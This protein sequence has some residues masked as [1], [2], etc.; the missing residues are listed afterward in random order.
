VVK[1]ASRSGLASRFLPPP[2][3]D[4][5]FGAELRGVVDRAFDGDTFALYDHQC[6]RLH[7]S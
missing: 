2:L 1:A 7:S 5:V 6:R 4:S 3:S